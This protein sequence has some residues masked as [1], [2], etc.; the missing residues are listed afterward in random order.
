MRIIAG[1]HKGRRLAP[2]KGADIRY[3]SD[4]VKKSL[5]SILRDDVPGARFLDLYAGSGNIG[6]EA[7]SRQAGSVA[8]VDLNPVCTKTIS[9][10]LSRCSLLPKPPRIMLLKMGISRAMEYFRRR[11]IQFDIIFLDPP[12]RLEL[13]GKTLHDISACGILSNDGEVI[14]EHDVREHVPVQAGKLV[15]TRQSRYGTTVL[16]FYSLA[17]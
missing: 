11:N 17:D 10:N 6:I 7:I 3:T 4:R 15:M 12:Y 5:F 9:A 8:F 14:A 16:S 13:V 2:V 1:E